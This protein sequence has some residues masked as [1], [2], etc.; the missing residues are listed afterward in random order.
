MWK[1]GF[2]KIR[3]YRCI[4][5]HVCGVN[6]VGCNE[7]LKGQQSGT[8]EQLQRWIDQL[9][10]SKNLALCCADTLQEVSYFKLEISLYHEKIWLVYCSI[11]ILWGWICKTVLMPVMTRLVKKAY[12]C[13]IYIQNTQNQT[14]E[15]RYNKIISNPNY[16]SSKDKNT[17]CLSTVSTENLKVNVRFIFL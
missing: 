2:V 14:V 17:G 7:L 3:L 13:Y 6:A 5:S 8:K 1:S 16:E 9:C 10:F 11:C 4:V 15:Y 12:F